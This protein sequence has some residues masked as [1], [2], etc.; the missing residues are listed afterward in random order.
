MRLPNPCP[1]SL[2]YEFI[3]YFDSPCVMMLEDHVIGGSIHAGDF[4][5]L[6]KGLDAR[7]AS[8]P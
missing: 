1:V 2:S 8:G 3:F 7:S 6:R 5:G 4:S